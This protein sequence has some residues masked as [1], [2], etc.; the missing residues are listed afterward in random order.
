MFEDHIP[1]MKHGG[2][3]SMVCFTASIKW[4]RTQSG[5]GTAIWLEYGQTWRAQQKGYPVKTINLFLEI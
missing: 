4:R 2:G 3:N 1:T 5:G